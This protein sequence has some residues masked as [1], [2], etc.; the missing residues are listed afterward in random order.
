MV[1]VGLALVHCAAGGADTVYAMVREAV[2]TDPA[3][4]EIPAA[5]L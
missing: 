4:D 5:T 2:C 3:A 1:M